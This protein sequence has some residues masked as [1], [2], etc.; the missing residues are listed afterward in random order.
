MQ[1][2]GPWGG[3]IRAMNSD[4]SERIIVL[5]DDGVLFRTREGLKIWDYLSGP[6]MDSSGYVT[7]FTINAS[8]D[9]F[10]GTN[11]G[12]WR[13]TDEGGTW[14]TLDLGINSNILTFTID[15]M[16]N[17][18][19]ARFYDTVLR[20]TDNGDHW[21]PLGAN[22]PPFAITTLLTLDDHVYAGTDQG[23]YRIAE[24]E[25]T[26]TSVSTGLFPPYVQTMATTSDGN[27]LVGTEGGIAYSSNQGD[28]WQWFGLVGHSI[29][30]IAVTPAIMIATSYQSGVFCSTDDG[31][32]WF[33][34]G[35]GFS[36]PKTAFI[37]PQGI[38]LVGSTLNGAIESNDGVTWSQIGPPAVNT[39]R[40]VRGIDDDLWA[41]SMSG[42]IFWSSSHGNEWVTVVESL[43][44]RRIVSAILPLSSDT[45]LAGGYSIGVYRSTDAGVT[46][47]PVNDGLPYV[48]VEEFALDSVGNILAGTREGLF[49]STNRGE[50]WAAIFPSEFI[51][52]MLVTPTG[53]IIVGTLHHGALRRLESDSSWQPINYG[54]MGSSVI[55][56]T[57]DDSGRIYA[58]S[59]F[60]G[61]F[62]STDGGDTWTQLGL[63]SFYVQDI[64]L[65]AIGDI[66]A[67]APPRG[68]YRSTDSGT[69]WE[70]VVSGLGDLYCDDLAIDRDGYL[71]AGTRSMGVFR[72]TVPTTDVVLD[73]PPITFLL[74]QNYPN[75][76]NPT[77]SIQF[78]IDERGWIILSIF[79]LLGREV[80]TLINEDLLP[81]SY[82]RTFQGSGLG[83]GV[84][85]YRLSTNKHFETR[86]M[87]LLR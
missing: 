80:S 41:T 20:S 47:D 24:N 82:K 4:L 54:L 57:M 69:T 59:N 25:S 38:L 19:A 86:S 77:T 75:P 9:L 7:A 3:N 87:I 78:H 26:W 71:Y 29:N 22:F 66:Y 13:S 76:F 23:V 36:Y 17:I 63:D 2:N 5:T 31:V 12:V 39:F 11:H 48:S 16:G 1:T 28:Q 10:V 65:N 73:S 51:V 74:E 85:F 52:T 46:W 62:R 44:R 79:D 70:I 30:C 53:G 43:D 84:Y 27:L 72:S 45:I 40:I 64:E 15:S 6:W 33:E 61:I 21:H 81:G 34:L 42:S 37:T 50:T 32:T 14:A 83:S 67:T 60:A 58:G 56:L 8:G 55:S 49:Q 35:I 68:I 18:Y